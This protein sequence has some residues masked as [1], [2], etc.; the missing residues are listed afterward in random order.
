MLHLL[1][2]ATS[3]NLRATAREASLDHEVLYSGTRPEARI[4][5]A[6]PAATRGPSPRPR[7]TAAVSRP[8]SAAA[9]ERHAQ[10]QALTAYPS[11]TNATIGVRYGISLAV[12]PVKWWSSDSMS[13]MKTVPEGRT[14]SSGN[15]N[16]G[17]ESTLP[18]SNDMY[19]FA[20]T[21]AS[22]KSE[23]GGSF[24]A[25]PSSSSAIFCGT[26]TRT[27]Q[28]QLSFPRTRR[29]SGPSL[30]SGLRV[31]LMRPSPTSTN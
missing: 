5:N 13:S 11:S 7:N 26:S 24:R 23:T 14:I 16:A 6:H 28:A 12:H 19:L 1:A 8:A 18:P 4:A 30:G 29:N 20:Y 27:A 2:Y 9:S 25:R 3:T 15:V 22:R 31:P 21:G 10:R 17:P